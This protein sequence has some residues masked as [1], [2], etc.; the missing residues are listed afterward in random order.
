MSKN[1][2]YI[3]IGLA[4]IWYFFVIAII[5]LIISI[6]SAKVFEDDKSKIKNDTN[7]SKTDYNLK[8]RIKCELKLEG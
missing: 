8:R 6:A 3:L 1:A 5:I 2:R 4:N 7:K